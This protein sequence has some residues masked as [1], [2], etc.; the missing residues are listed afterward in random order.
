MGNSA[1]AAQ[2]G[3]V[4]SPTEAI[5][6]ILV[7]DKESIDTIIDEIE[8]QEGNYDGATLEVSAGSFMMGA[9]GTNITIDVIGNDTK[10]LEE[11]TNTIN[12]NIK[13]I[14]GIEEVTTN[15]EEKKTIYSFEVDPT[16]GKSQNK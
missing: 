8:R 10:E 2:Y 4:S 13:D 11:T 16:K 15:M 5:F 1:E 6:S 9:A 14:D 7:K 3:V 12:E